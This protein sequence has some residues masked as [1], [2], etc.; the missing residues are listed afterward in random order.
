MASRLTNARSAT[1]VTCLFAT[2][3]AGIL[4]WATGSSLN[5]TS[6]PLLLATTCTVVMLAL[7]VIY[8]RLRPE[9]LLST[10]TGGIAAI[11]WGGLLAAIL[12]LTALRTGA[13]LIDPALA[14]VDAALDLSTPALVASV[15][16]HPLIAGILRVAYLSTVPWV[17][18]T[19]LLLAVTGRATEMWTLCFCFAATAA[20]CALFSAVA[21]AAGAFAYYGTEPEVLAALPD[22]AGLFHLDIFEKYRAGQQTIVD[23]GDAN[24]VV[25]FP[26]FHAAMALMCAHALHHYRGLSPIA[27]LWCVVTLVA[28]VPIGGHYAIDLIGGAT[29]WGAFA[30]IANA[31]T[32]RPAQSRVPAAVPHGA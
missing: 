6:P 28:T 25:T 17:V 23:I 24:G 11:S 15:S 4:L 16:Q 30:L 22:H 2:V 10:V 21:P 1:W 19:A 18:C 29:A 27:W 12:A 5:I 3:A 32:T 26:S 13:P 20:S 7:H 9:P 8:E 31:L 14:Q